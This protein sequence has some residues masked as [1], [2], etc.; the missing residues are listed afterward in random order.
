LAHSISMLLSTEDIKGQTGEMVP[1]EHANFEHLPL[2]GVI[3]LMSKMQADIRNAEADMLTHFLSQ[4]DASMF[5]FNKIEAIV[6]ANSNY[7]LAGNPYDARVFIAASDSTQEPIIYLNGGTRLAIEDGK[8]VYSGAT[9]TPG[10]VNWG[11]VIKLVNPATE[12]T[13]S[14]PF[15]S[16]YQVGEPSLVISATKMNV[17]YIGVPNPVAISVPGVPDDKIT[18]SIS[19]G[20]ITRSGKEYVVDVRRPGTANISV[21]ADL[22][23]GP[24]SMGSKEFRVKQV[25]DPVPQVAGQTTSGRLGKSVLLAQPGVFAIMQNFDFDLKF[26]VVSFSVSANIRGFL[27]E[28]ATSSA[29][30]TAEQKAIMQQVLPNQKVYI[31]NIKARGPDG[32]VR[33]LPPLTFTLN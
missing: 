19:S 24:Q 26:D 28:A 18:A 7:V 29:R 1:W 2:V 20:T 10:I 31:E 27:Q 14:F 33:S 17:F 5:K 22:G 32:T 21:S 23:N 8:G 13:M 16:T 30:F 15:E 3:T 12:D 6:T 9:S 11:G 4:I 25:P